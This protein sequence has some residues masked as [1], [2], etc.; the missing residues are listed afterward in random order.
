MIPVRNLKNPL[1]SRLWQ[2][3]RSSVLSNFPTKIVNPIPIS[4]TQTLVPPIEFFL[5]DYSN[6]L[7]FGTAYKLKKNIEL[8]TKKNINKKLNRK[9]EKSIFIQ[10]NYI[11]IYIY[12]LTGDT[13]LPE[14]TN[15]ETE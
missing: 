13:V 5:F 11:Y 10:I 15:G 4:P 2:R 14:M 9:Q 1:Y 8:V 7:T 3:L 12:I 6:V